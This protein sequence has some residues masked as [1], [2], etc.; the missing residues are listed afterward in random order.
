MNQP[1]LPLQTVDRVEI[2]TLMDN[3]V[4]VLLGNKDRVTRPLH[5]RDGIIEENALL[6]EHGLSLLITVY[7][8]KKT[9]TILFDT[10]YSAVGV[11]HNMAYLGIQPED[12]KILVLSHGHMDH[13]GSL[14]PLIE[15]MAKPMTLVVHP[16]A[17][18]HPRYIQMPD[19]EKR[20][21]PRTLVRDKLIKE[22]VDIQES[23]TP[24]AIADGMVLVTGEVER[25]TSFEKG[26]PNAFYIKDD[27]PIPDPIWDDQ[28]LILNVKD[29]GLV[30]ISGCSHAGIINT[31]LYAK[32]ITG[33][34]TV[35]ALMG[36]F[37]LSGS[38]FEKII[39]ETILEMLTLNPEVIVPMHCTGWTAIHRFSDAFPD[40]FVL[41]S[42]GTNIVL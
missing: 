32:K 33:V 28:S 37:H 15:R 42:V 25:T 1:F 11:L 17:F 12:L 14:Y 19:G 34:E 23:T 6:A 31:V 13:T 20:Q 3:Y 35:Y 36:G 18:V 9:D 22:G 7:R 21:F 2:L 30:V 10:G 40:A 27:K 41:N 8:G 24:V 26:M 5:V 38:F 4:D 16:H 39:E 29:K